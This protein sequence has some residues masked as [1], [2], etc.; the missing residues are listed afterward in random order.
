MKFMSSFDKTL[1]E[2]GPPA[3]FRLSHEEELF[4]DV[5][6]SRDLYRQN[7]PPYA[8][9][10]CHC[11]IVDFETQ[12]PQYALITSPNLF[13]AYAQGSV[14]RYATYS[15]AREAVAQ[16]KVVFYSQKRIS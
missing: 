7:D 12:W 8:L 4:V 9:E 15:L 16:Q 1:S 6:R 5:M 13:E 2:I 3:L 10:L 14:V 11:M